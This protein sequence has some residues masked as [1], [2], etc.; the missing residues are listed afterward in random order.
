MRNKIVAILGAI[1]LFAVWSCSDESLQMDSSFIHSNSRA[2]HT[3]EVAIQLSTFKLDSVLTSNQGVVWVG[4][5]NKPV[6]GDIRSE[7]FMKMTSPVRTD[8]W[9]WLKKERYDSIEI[10]LRHTG[11]YEGDT[12]QNLILNVNHLYYG[13]ILVDS[14]GTTS[15]DYIRFKQR[16][17]AFYNVD[18]FHVGKNLGRHLFKPRPHSKPR[19]T[20]RLNDDFGK[21]LVDFIKNNKKNG[22]EAEKYYYEHILGGINIS[23]DKSSKSLCA[24]L[25]DSVQ[26]ILHSHVSDITNTKR[27]R[28]L[29]I[30][31]IDKQ[32]NHVWNENMDAPYETLTTRRKQVTESEGG[33]HSVQFEGLGYYTRINFPTLNNVLDQNLYAHVAKATLTLYAEKGSFDKKRVP[34]TFFLTEINEDNVLGN[35]VINNTRNVVFAQRHYDTFE[36][37]NIYYTFDLTYYINSRLNNE[38]LKPTDGLVLTWANGM[39]P[40]NYNFMNFMGHDVPTGMERFRSKLDITYYYYDREDR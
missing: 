12:M 33:K 31:D 32:F 22:A 35:I 19:I 15:Y 28:V 36:L 9:E 24:F 38:F 8:K 21:L 6:I 27:M 13:R 34:P 3:D 29:T 23:A 16:Q 18:S 11:A 20:F 17:N 1:I 30:S 10:V 2:E 4:K 5:A 37:D 40:M 26:I 7:S 25:S 14:V 39:N